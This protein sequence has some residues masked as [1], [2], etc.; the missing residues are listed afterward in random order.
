MK[1]IVIVLVMCAISGLLSA[2]AGLKSRMPMVL[3][4]MHELLVQDDPNTCRMYHYNFE[5]Q[6][7]RLYQEGKIDSIL[8]VIDYIKNECGPAAN[9]EVSH[10]LLM[11]EGGR[12]A[13]SLVGQV[14]VPQMLWYRTEEEFSA[15]WLRRSVLF[16]YGQPIDNTHEQF[17]EFQTQLA[18]RVAAPENVEPSEESIGLFYSG[19]FDSAFSR[20]QADDMQGTGLRRSYDDLV[21][22]TRLQFPERG[23]FAFL[24]GNW[25]PQGNN[26]LFGPHVELGLQGGPEWHRWRLDFT[27]N[28]R[29]S[30]SR[31][32]FIVDSLGQPVRTDKFNSWL[33]G[34]EIGYKVFDNAT[35]STDFFVGVGYD[36]VFS[37]TEAGDP[38]EYKS[39]G[40][41][42]LSAGIRQR[43]FLNHQSGWYLGGAVRYSKVDYGNSGGTDL[44]GNTLTVSLISGWSLHA[45]LKQFL[46]KLNY[47]GNWRP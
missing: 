5:R 6:A 44:S 38:E 12:F 22:R 11:C 34:G 36:V 30:H 8:N 24:L 3:A 19:S 21:A 45:T 28:Y 35:L 1:Q 40:S 39:H 2:C 20:I 42:A 17:K 37:I 23:H 32:M 25:N 43:V 9:L 47:K 41:L 46:R 15:W 18:E 29:F 33:F 27:I 4:D 10:L 7:P 16:G 13:D 26:R 31:E 14:T